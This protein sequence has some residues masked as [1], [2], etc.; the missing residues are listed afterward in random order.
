MAAVKM[1]FN[2]SIGWKGTLRPLSGRNCRGFIPQWLS[3]LLPILGLPT[4]I[5]T[6]SY[7]GLWFFNG[8]RIRILQRSETPSIALYNIVPYIKSS[9]TH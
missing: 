4:A 5:S 8:F 7:I 6:Y 9:R 2:R 1:A 3:I